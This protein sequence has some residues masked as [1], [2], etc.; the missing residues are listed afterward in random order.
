L[1]GNPARAQGQG[2]DKFRNLVEGSIQG[3]L[4]HRGFRVLFAND[5]LATLCG[6]A[7]GEA[8]VGMDVADFVPKEELRTRQDFYT[9]RIAGKEA[10]D[11]FEGGVLRS[12]GS[13]VQ[14]EMI[15]KRVDWEGA[16]AVQVTLFDITDRIL[17]EQKLRE[18]DFFFSV[19]QAVANIG[20]WARDL[21]RNE[22]QWSPQT[23]RIFGL[24]PSD[25]PVSYEQLCAFIPPEDLPRFKATVEQSVGSSDPIDYEHRIVRADGEVRTVHQQGH[26]VFDDSG[27]PVRRIGVVYDITERKRLEEQLRQAQKLEAVG[28]L[29][30]GVAHEFNNILQIIKGFAGLGLENTAPDD[31]A[32][33]IWRPIDE[34]TDRA[35]GLVKQL[36]GFGQRQLLRQEEVD[37]NSLISR[38]SNFVRPTLGEHIRVV[39]RAGGNLSPCWADKGSIDQILM[40][41]CINA[42]DA[43]PRGGRLTLATGNVSLDDAFC[44]DNPWAKPGEYVR[45]S[46]CDT[47]EGMDEELLQ[48]IFEP[49]YTTKGPKKGSGLGLSMVYG[50]IEQHN[51]L[52]NVTSR[53]G[54]GTTFELYFP[55]VAGDDGRAVAATREPTILVAEDDHSVQALAAK[56]LQKDGY[57][58]LSVT[59]GRAAVQT[60]EADADEIDLVLLDLVMPGMGGR[61]VYD[62]IS[63]CRPQVPI[64]FHSAHHLDSDETDFIRMRGLPLLEKPYSPADLRERVA[65]LLG[66]PPAMR[67]GP[68]AARN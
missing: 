65:R 64:L 41:L 44:R 67:V 56:V 59:D 25:E 28:Q 33:E 9:R 7:S 58:V 42:R 8:M 63:A 62:R 18:N 47:G 35:S 66:E 14:T 52:I 10:P 53:P 12:D 23:Y 43:M 55:A 39:V 54:S 38:L 20:I 45:I 5:A 40:N 32:R 49:F 24:E 2:E 51:G 61:E 29:A 26:T 4:V 37:V 22:L 34:A 48:H 21:V 30:G 11:S 60:F 3:I 31:P 27:R 46:V 68:Q 15:A 19:A 16:P 1:R 57:R 17:A 36:L 6:Y 13:L 50:L